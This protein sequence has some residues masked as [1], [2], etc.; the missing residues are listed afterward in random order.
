MIDYVVYGGTQCG[1][2]QFHSMT[3]LLTSIWK[4]SSKRYVYDN[5]RFN[6]FPLKPVIHDRL[7][8]A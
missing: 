2:L 7:S 6:T 3:I 5:R 1:S 8:S 4:Q